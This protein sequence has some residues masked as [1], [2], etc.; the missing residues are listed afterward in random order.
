MKTTLAV[1][2]LCAVLAS[3]ACTPDT[4]GL[5]PNQTL[6]DQFSIKVSPL[7]GGGPSFALGVNSTLDDG[8]GFF[9]SLDLLPAD[10]PTDSFDLGVFQLSGGQLYANGG[11][12]A[13]RGTPLLSPLQLFVASDSA[14]SSVSAAAVTS[15]SADGKEIQVIRILNV[16]GLASGSAAVKE[17]KEGA[18]LYSPILVGLLS[19]GTLVNWEVVPLPSS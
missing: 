9:Y 3:A 18:S 1:S 10:T 14:A 7:S 6:P 17:L 5:H 15:C 16:L 4:L 12:L 19:L 11:V 13:S 8:G 2:A